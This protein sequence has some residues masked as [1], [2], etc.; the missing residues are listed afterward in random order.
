MK[1]QG[2]KTLKLQSEVGF[3]FSVKLLLLNCLRLAGRQLQVLMLKGVWWFFVCGRKFLF[4]KLGIVSDVIKR[5]PV[6]HS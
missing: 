5:S 6:F 1:L 4:L 2:T 3:L